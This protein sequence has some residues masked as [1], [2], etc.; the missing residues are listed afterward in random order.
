MP[1]LL[2]PDDAV[3]RIL[4]GIAPIGD[5]SVPL[6]DA[7]NRILATSITSDIDLPPFANSSMDGFAVRADDTIGASSDA[8]VRLNVVMDIPAGSFPDHA[9]EQ[10]QAA[11]IMTGAPVPEGATAVIPVENTDQ[12]WRGGESSTTT[13]EVSLFSSVKTGDSIRLAGEDIARGQIVLNAG[14][15]IR[16]QELGVLAALGHAQVRV[17]RRPKVA[18]LSTGDELIPVDQPLTPG[19][20]RDTNA[21]TLAGLITLYGGEPITIP[22]AKDTLEDA[23]LRFQ[24]AL[25]R[26]PDI[27]LS[28]AGVSVGAF[29]VVR[30]VLDELGE[31]DFW[32]V[33]LRPGKPVAFGSIGASRIPFFGLPGNPVSA[34]VTFDVFVRPVL[35][36]MTRRA[37]AIPTINATV[38]EPIRSDGRRSYLRAFLSHKSDGW[39]ARLTGTQSSGALMSM[40]LA[41][42]LLIVPEGMT[43]VAVGTVLPVRLLKDYTLFTSV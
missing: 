26:Q 35:L 16:P 9:L 38:D 6:R 4:S 33:N 24:E 11:R 40:V 13:T 10:G 22:T 31:I 41:D 5:E 12:N 42:G 27:V 20:I 21:Y 37:D 2:N 17:I 30:T 32:R 29:D 3:A 43:D 34:M 36:K 28:S 23:R 1:D 15:L 7:L 14:T 8:P 18:I 39:H 19:K 25:D